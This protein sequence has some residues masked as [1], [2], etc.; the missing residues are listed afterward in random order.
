MGPELLPLVPVLPLEEM[1]LLLV[2]AVVVE[3]VV[4]GPVV[5][6]EGD[7]VTVLTEVVVIVVV[8]VPLELP[9]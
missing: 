4:E 7:T 2:V 6:L 1:L 9:A 5:E 8:C 3:L